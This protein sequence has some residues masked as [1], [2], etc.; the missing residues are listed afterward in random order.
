MVEAKKNNLQFGQRIKA[1]RIKAGLDQ[2]KF[3]KKLTPVA[4]AS[5]VSR[6]ERGINR[7]NANRIKQIND[8]F[9]VP[10][11]FLTDKNSTNIEIATALKERTKRYENPDYLGDDSEE[12]SRLLHINEEFDDDATRKNYLNNIKNEIDNLDDVSNTG[13]GMIDASVKLSGAFS[14][15][16]KN[17]SANM[18][19]SLIINDLSIVSLALAEQING[20]SSNHEAVQNAL[21]SS[22]KNIQKFL[23]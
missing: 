20:S 14:Q 8:K 7:P 15:A 9:N 1:I 18:Q 19:T 17:G 10:D 22:L 12:L 4:S 21:K 5:L 2:E 16:V 13:L 6:W 11:L 3:G 23:K